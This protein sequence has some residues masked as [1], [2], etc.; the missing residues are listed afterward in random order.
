MDNARTMPCVPITMSTHKN[1]ACLQK[2]LPRHI[3]HMKRE[4]Q[5]EGASFK[6]T[7]SNYYI[8]KIAQAAE[9]NCRTSIL[10]RTSVLKAEIIWTH[11]KK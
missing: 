3:I 4:P 10:C 9:Q 5:Q 6:A 8:Q 11:E 7:V 2:F 1:D